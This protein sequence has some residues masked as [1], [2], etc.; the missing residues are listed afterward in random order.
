M[1][2]ECAVVT[3]GPPGKS[4]G[5]NFEIRILYVGRLSFKYQ[6]M[7]FPGGTVVKNPPANAGD[8]GSSAGPGRSHMPR[9]NQACVPQL[10]SL[11]SRAHVLQLLKPT[12]LEPVLRN[13]R[14][15]RNEKTTHLKEEQPPFDTTKESP[16][17]AMRPNAAKNK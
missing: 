12:R 11:S 4:K 3:T 7:G 2:W 1:H 5:K 10:L 15:H 9:S 8:M 14:N 13:R 6:G 17:S 16:G